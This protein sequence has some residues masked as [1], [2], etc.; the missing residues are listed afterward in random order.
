MA[1]SMVFGKA[2]CFGLVQ[3]INPESDL[4]LGVVCY[5][6][7]NTIGAYPNRQVSTTAAFSSSILI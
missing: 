1:G 5:Y 4:I 2:L 6:Y 3:T 7:G